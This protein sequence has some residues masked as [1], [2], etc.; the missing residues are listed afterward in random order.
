MAE[1]N[2][3][4]GFYFSGLIK[5]AREL[6]KKQTKAEEFLW[7]ILRN[8]KFMGLK[9]RRQHQI[10]RYIADFYCD[11]KKLIIELDG[12]VHGTEKQKKHDKKRDKYLKALG[13]K[14]I[15]FS[16]HAVFDNTE[17]VLNSIAA[18]VRP[19]TLSLLPNEQSSP[20]PLHPSPIGRGAGGE[21]NLDHRIG[22]IWHTQGSG[23]SLSMVF[24]TGKI[25]SIMDNPT[26]VMLTDRNDLDDQLFGTFG[27]CKGNTTTDACAG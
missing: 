14:I 6:R 2:Y 12:G 4:G 19:S 17:V 10:G 1:D 15:R 8:K 9:F 11:E 22:V 23:K 21:G 5:E 20:S 25:V 27:N 7:K 13:N 3:R 24:Y 26:I 18:N 16:N